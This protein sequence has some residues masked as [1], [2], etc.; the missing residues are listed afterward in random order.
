MPGRWFLIPFD[1]IV[2]LAAVLALM[3]AK[4]LITVEAACTDNQIQAALDEADSVALVRHVADPPVSKEAIYLIPD[5]P[6]RFVESPVISSQL[7]RGPP[8]LS[9]FPQSGPF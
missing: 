1:L 6:V 4:K 9:L 7:Y 8:S 5:A 3:P 2:I